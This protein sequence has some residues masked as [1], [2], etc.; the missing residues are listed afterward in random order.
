MKELSAAHPGRVTEMRA[1][2]DAWAKR[3][4]VVPWDEVK[5]HA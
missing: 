5:K 3:C 4:N 1:L 2:Y